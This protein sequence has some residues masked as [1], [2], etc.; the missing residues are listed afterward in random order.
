MRCGIENCTRPAYARGWCEMHYARW[1][2][3]GK[4]DA[5]KFQYLRGRVEDRFWAKVAKGPGCWE[6][7]GKRHYK[8]YGHFTVRGQGRRRTLKA[9][10]V[11]WELANGPIPEG[12]HVLHS[13]DNPPCVNPDHLFLG[14]DMDNVHDRDAKGRRNV[15]GSRSWKAQLVEEQ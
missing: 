13:C 5:V 4:P 2:R 14:T 1:R 12:L 15:A 6:W 9:H 11:S 8:G 3:H 7:Q 10:R